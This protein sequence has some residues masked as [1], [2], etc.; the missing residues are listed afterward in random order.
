MVLI[1]IMFVLFTSIPTF[2]DVSLVDYILS[3]NSSNDWLV[4][5]STILWLA[6]TACTFLSWGLL[7]T[8]KRWAREVYCAPGVIYAIFL[9]LPSQE[10]DTGG[11]FQSL[12]YL[13]TIYYGIFIGMLY[14]GPISKIFSNNDEKLQSASGA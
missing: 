4:N 11:I 1:D 2:R 13:S 7:L 14:F 8:H 10:T 3:I 9:I 12:W 5:T 6:G